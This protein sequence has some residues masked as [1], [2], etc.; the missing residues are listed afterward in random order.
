MFDSKIK[1]S[2]YGAIA[3]VYFAQGDTERTLEYIDT[4]I[5]V[6]NNPKMIVELK[7]KKAEYLKQNEEIEKAFN[8]YNSIPKNELTLNAKYGIFLLHRENE[9]Y[10]KAIDIGIGENLFLAFENDFTTPMSKLSDFAYYLADCFRIQ[11]YLKY[12]KII[13]YMGEKTH[14]NEETQFYIADCEIIKELYASAKNYFGL[15]LDYDENPAENTKQ[16]K[17]QMKKEIR[18]IDDQIIP[19]LESLLK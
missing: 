19:A 6:S 18:K 14:S 5:D 17:R 7:I 10:E 16:F 12:N 13:E 8:V 2:C 11:A 3:E 4:A 15:S 9:N 1:D